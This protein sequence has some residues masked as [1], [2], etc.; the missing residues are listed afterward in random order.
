MIGGGGMALKDLHRNNKPPRFNDDSDNGYGDYATEA[1]GNMGDLKLNSRRSS[2]QNSS[3]L[4]SRRESDQ[5]RN[6]TI[7]KPFMKHN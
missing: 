3:H 1:K 6:I 4:N 7:S 5:I 2:K